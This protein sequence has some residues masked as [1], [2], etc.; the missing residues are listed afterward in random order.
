MGFRRDQSFATLLCLPAPDAKDRKIYKGGKGEEEEEGDINS[1][2][3]GAGEGGSLPKGLS[4]SLSQNS[5]KFPV[6]AVAAGCCA[7]IG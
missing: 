2:A 6:T 4:F 1:E 3:E 5:N 7:A